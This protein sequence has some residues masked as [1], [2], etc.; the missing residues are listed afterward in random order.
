MTELAL[1]TGGARNIGLAIATRL[2]AD[3]YAV[4]VLDR[5]KPEGADLGSFVRA[6]LADPDATAAVLAE[7]TAERAIT[8]LV[9]NAGIVAPAALA[10]ATLAQFDEAMAVNARAAMQ[11]A[12][13]LL[14]AMR[15]A[16]FGRIVNIGSTSA[17]G[18]PARSTYAASKLALHAL[19]LTWAVELAPHGITVNTVAPGPI[20]TA[21][22]DQVNS[23]A[24]TREAVARIP[25]GRLGRPE[26]VANA[27]SFFLGAGSGFVTGQALSV[28]GGVSV[29]PR[30]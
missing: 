16:G 24:T 9:N 10:E 25:A 19:T 18:K 3:G 2:A 17:S 13:A 23:P 22:W 15:Q 30:A 21:L 7:L 12:Q 8:R 1:V 26:D 28:C 5:V 11:C 6:D 4:V 29:G 14:P 20:H 27:V